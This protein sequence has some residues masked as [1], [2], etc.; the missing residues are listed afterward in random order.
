M[1]VRRHDLAPTSAPKSKTR[2]AFARRGFFVAC[3]LAECAHSTWP[4]RSSALQRLCQVRQRRHI[5]RFVSG[6]GIAKR[7]VKGPVEYR[8]PAATK[9]A[10]GHAYSMFICDREPAS[11]ACADLQPQAL[12]LF[13]MRAQ[14]G[15]QHGGQLPK[16]SY[17]G[18]MQAVVAQS[19]KPTEAK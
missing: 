9:L 2:D 8:V 18:R 14:V 11:A 5:V 3:R 12:H 1:R 17:V 13:A 4:S 16:R 10:V 6:W 7:A 19:T 15:Q